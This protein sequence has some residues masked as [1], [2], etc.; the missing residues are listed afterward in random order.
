M[1]C[2]LSC[3]NQSLSSRGPT[4]VPVLRTYLNSLKRALVMVLH[5]GFLINLYS[6]AVLSVAG[7]EQAITPSVIILDSKNFDEAISNGTNGTLLEFYS[8]W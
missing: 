6:R 5:T 3:K 1:E 7:S 8:P 4:R 2:L